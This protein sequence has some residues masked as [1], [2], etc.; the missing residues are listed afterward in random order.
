VSDQREVLEVDVVL[1]G[2]GPAGLSTAFHLA[3]LIRDYNRGLEEGRVRGDRLSPTILV[4]EKSRE[5]GGHALSGAVVDPIAFNELL[6]GTDE[7]PPPYDGPVR[8]DEVRFLTQSGGLRLPFTPPALNNDGLQLAS[9]GVLVRWL[10]KRCEA[11]DVE[12]YPGFPAVELLVED[13]TV[14]GVRTGDSGID[15]E[16]NPKANFEPGM[17][18]RAKVTVLGEGPRGT[19]AGQ[20]FSKLGLR[21]QCQ[22]QIYALGVKELWQSSGETE[23][24]QVLHTLGYPLDGSDFGGGF[25]YTMSEGVIALGFVVGLDSPDPRTD[26]HR[27]LQRWKSHP[28]VRARLDGATLLSYGA[29][30]I[31]EGGFWAMP[32]L[33][34]DGLVVVGD[35][36]GFLNAQRLKGIHLA[37][38]SGMLAAETIFDALCASD[39]SRECLSSCSTRFEESW[40]FE[41]LR[42]VR[43][44][45]QA[46]QGGFWKGLGHAAIQMATGGR[47]L[48]DPFPIQEGYRRMMAPVESA[49][50]PSLEP[51]GV[52]TFDRMTSVFHAD[53]SHEEDQPSHLKI[54]DP[55]VCVTRCGKE[56]GH[57][58]LYFCP[59]GVYEF[60]GEGAEARLQVNFSNC[61][62][63]KS[64]EIADPY[65]I[66]LWTPPEGGGGPNWKKM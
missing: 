1:V 28:S 35:S 29:K 52:V 16:G 44:F 34:A 22:P 2:A 45:R 39:F 24:G 3:R 51:D 50:Q 32:R 15:R 5:I 56:F 36:A 12:V 49:N 38:K 19:L 47:G 62:H 26:P 17:E 18:V 27:L 65:Q 9:L 10:A 42:A 11:L 4:L 43:N 14:V 66:I 41:E 48:R 33:W 37:V 54:L 58:C 21:E 8:H 57:P 55:S 59:A 7:E 20:A 63:C 60:Q 31:P 30:A 46:F 40:A 61:V 64:C 13:G 6:S 53:T 23:P 25:L